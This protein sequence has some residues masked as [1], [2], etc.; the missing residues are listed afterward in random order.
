MNPNY[1][2]EFHSVEAGSEE[3]LSGNIANKSK[4]ITKMTIILIVILTLVVIGSS[5]FTISKSS[6]L[7][8]QNDEIEKIQEQIHNRS[9]YLDSI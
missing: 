2:S 9:K 7:K 1:K 4:K 3:I 5:F 8:Q 6:E